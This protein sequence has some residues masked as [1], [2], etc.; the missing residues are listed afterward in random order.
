MVQNI[1]LVLVLAITALPLRAIADGAGTV[2]KDPSL[3]HAPLT[4]AT[5]HTA[6]SVGARIERPDLV[7]R[8][9]LVYR[10]GDEIAEIA[11]QR[12]DV[13][14]WPY[15]AVIPAEHVNRPWLAYAIEIERTDGARVPVFASRAVMQPVEVVGDNVD[16]EEEALLARLHGRRFVLSA[17]SEFAYFGSS[18]TQVCSTSPCS[19]KDGAPRVTQNVSDYYYRVE[20]GFTYRML[21][22]VSEFG[23]RG[24]AYRGRSIVANE[25]DA[26]KYD[27]GINY[28]APWLRVRAT[29]WLHLE[30]EFLTS[31]TEV[32]FSLGG[33]G[34]VLIGDAYASH[35][36]LGF[37]SIDVF[38]T[39]G[40]SRF[41]VTALPW[42][43]IA[44]SVEVT[45]MPHASSAGVRLLTDFGI[46]AG[47]GWVITLRGGYQARQFASGGPAA[48]GAL[49]YAF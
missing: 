33:G 21:R 49:S 44:P 7:K 20:G 5:E 3:H 45:S 42:L 11:F 14:D 23:I 37:E 39:R 30:G 2:A 6:I 36:T 46:D 8:S 34:A 13:H 43:T 9:V 12:S 40:Y 24:G 31:V 48:G 29:D 4:T 38:G 10:H 15:V 26:A 41:D 27:V 17:N 19:P 16:A 18:S 22:T 28:G 35:L 25:Q 32:G 1:C 47:A